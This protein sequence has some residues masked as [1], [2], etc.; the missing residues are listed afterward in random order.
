MA[1]TTN[2]SQAEFLAAKEPTGPAPV[3]LLQIIRGYRVDPLQRWTAIRAEHGDVAR[4]RFGFDDTFFI[5]SADGARRILQENA[6]NYTKDHASYGMIRKLVGN[7]LLTSEGSFWLRQRRL[8]QPAF[9]RQRIAAMGAQ[10]T[11]AAVILADRWVARADDPS[12]ISMVH[13]MSRLTLR[14]VGDA[15][16]GTD[17]AAD[18]SVVSAAWDV[19]NAQMVERHNKKRLLPPILPTRYDRDFR[20]ARRTV[21]GTVEKIIAAKRAQGGGGSDLL[22][23][24]MSARDEDTGEQMTDA[25]LRDEAVTM[26]LAGH[27]TTSLTLSWAWALL[28]QHPNV[29]ARLREELSQVLGGRVPTA[30][31]MPRLPYTRAVIEETMRLYP[32]AYIMFR[33]VQENDVVCGYRVYKGG[34]IVLTPVILHRNPAYWPEPNAFLPERFLDPDAE[35][36]RPRFSYLPFSGGPRQCIGNNF[37]MLEA[38]L[39]LATLAQCFE[40]RIAK[41]YTLAPEYLVTLRPAGGLPMNLERV[42]Q[43]VGASSSVA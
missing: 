9:H 3:S 31:D 7:G 22:S 33:R 18:A 28:D 15:L 24:L 32:P 14:I 5:S 11:A 20:N 38:V 19:L 43:P 21:F 8:A 30:E 25:Q 37:A 40:P 39:I 23:V 35:K 29:G 1:P 42:S 36:K 2:A 12:P 41:G 34:V 4:Y 16:F 27:E 26:L 13:E 10:M 6:S 17:L